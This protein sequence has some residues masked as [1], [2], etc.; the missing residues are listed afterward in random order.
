MLNENIVIIRTKDAFNKDKPF[1]VNQIISKNKTSQ[2]KALKRLE[3]FTDWK[4]VVA[5]MDDSQLWLVI[6]EGEQKKT[7]KISHDGKTIN[8]DDTKVDDYNGED[9][10]EIDAVNALKIYARRLD[11]NNHGKGAYFSSFVNDSEA[12]DELNDISD[13]DFTYIT[14][15]I[16]RRLSDTSDIDYIDHIFKAINAK[17]QQELFVA[18]PYMSDSWEIGHVIVDKIRL[19]KAVEKVIIRYDDID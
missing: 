9:I 12:P 7:L 1:S 13:W 8:W 2:N 17:T 19:V 16:S 15:V 6:T 4:V 5:K 11:R 10:N 3:E 18:A 14:D